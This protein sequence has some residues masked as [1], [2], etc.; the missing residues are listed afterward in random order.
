MA[1]DGGY[2]AKYGV[3]VDLESAG[4]M[5]SSGNYPAFVSALISSDEIAPIRFSADGLSHS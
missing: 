5:K 3:D 4:D 2:F 1:Q